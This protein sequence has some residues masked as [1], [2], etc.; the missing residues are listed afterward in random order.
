MQRNHRVAVAIVALG[1]VLAGAPAQAGNYPRC[2]AKVAEQLGEY[3]IGEAD[4]S[5]IDYVRK[6]RAV[7]R[8]REAIS[9]VTAWVSLDAC[10]GSV[11]IVMNTQCRMKQAY[12]R[13]Q[14]RVPG[15]KSF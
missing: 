7:S 5:G 14:C 10:K 1:L 9:G 15:L 3:G 2:E 12:T 4:I 11:V 8:S 13:G 6:V